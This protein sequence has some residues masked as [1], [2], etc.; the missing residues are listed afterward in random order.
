M[1]QNISIPGP[2]FR[3]ESAP[4]LPYILAPDAAADFRTGFDASQPGPFSAVLAV[5]NLT[6]TLSATATP[7]AALYLAGSS[8]PLAG[9][10]TIDFGSTLRGTSKSQGFVLQNN[11]TIGL[12]VSS[13]RVTGAAFH[14]PAGLTP[15][16][17]L[18]PGASMPFRIT[19]EPPA[20]QPQ[21]GTLTIDQRTFAL[22]GLGLDPPLPTASIVFDSH[23]PLSAQQLH[24]S[25]P[26][27]NAS[28]INGTGTLTLD[29]HPDVSG[30]GDDPA[31]QFLSGPPRVATVT[32]AP[33][34]T[35]AK[36]YGETAL[37]FQTGT[38]AGT[39]TFTLTLPNATE[40]ANLTV[41]PATIDISSATG[42]RRVGNLD[43]SIV[44][45]D[46]TYSASTLAFTFFDTTG[47]TIQPGVIRVDQTSAF[48]AYFSSAQDGGAFAL[49]ATFPVTGDVNQ[50]KAV[51]VGMTNSVGTTQSQQ[52]LFE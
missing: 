15:P 50:V 22:T 38:T 12:K 48:H 33:G 9:G 10:A 25:I 23:M 4:S 30:V 40:Q 31:I 34:D 16:V 36:F 28:E 51:A 3:I 18:A 47:K 39:I 52:I 26:L 17:Q 14:G 44:G 2:V 29:F 46:N 45:L 6:V 7:G 11:G 49:R 5:N 24:V 27:A 43:V 41:T 19:F 1:L 13:I 20:G 32:I 42:V 8:T 37:A 21:Q 35:A